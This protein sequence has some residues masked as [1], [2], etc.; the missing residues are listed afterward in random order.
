MSNIKIE[1]RNVLPSIEKR[2]RS[3]FLR[4]PGIV[5][6][7][8]S[9]SILLPHPDKPGM[10]LKIKGAGLNG[11]T[12]IYG[13]FHT[14]GPRSVIFDFDGRC[15]EDMASGHNNAYLGA[16]SFQQAAVEYFISL[17]LANLGYSVVPCIGYGYIDHYDQIAW[18]SVFE[19]GADWRIVDETEQANI[20]N[21][22]LL[23][24]LAVKHHLIGYFWFMSAANGHVY[25]KDLHPFRYADPINMSQISWTLQVISALYIRCKACELFAQKYIKD[26]SNSELAAIPLQAILPDATSSDYL[27]LKHTIIDPYIRGQPTCFSSKRLLEDLRSTRVANILLDLCPEPFTRLL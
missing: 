7:D 25:L 1:I 24:E 19:L 21:A 27:R 5:A 22:R 26:K 18:F 10:V 20:Q 11:R 2:V 16:T 4:R 15:M 14:K 9:R 17:K 3:W 8:G 23:I 13:T 12:Q 6:L